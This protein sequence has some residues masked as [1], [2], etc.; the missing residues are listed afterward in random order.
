M[1]EF[2]LEWLLGNSVFVGVY[3]GLVFQFLIILY[4]KIIVI[5]VWQGYRKVLVICKIIEEFCLRN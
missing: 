2:I 4:V 5:K 3:L 1:F